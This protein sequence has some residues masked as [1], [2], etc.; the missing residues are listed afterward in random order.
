[1][2][3]AVIQLC[4]QDDVPKNLARAVALVGEAARSGAQLV[5]LPENFA[6]MGDEAASGSSPRRPTGRG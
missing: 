2:L 1:M 6:Y 4:S 3:A 5:V